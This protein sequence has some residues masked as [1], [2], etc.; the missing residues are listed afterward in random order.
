[1]FIRE[2]SR[3]WM[4]LSSLRDWSH[5]SWIIPPVIFLNVFQANLL[6]IKWVG[7]ISSCSG[8]NSLTACQCYFIGKWCWQYCVSD[9]TDWS[10]FA[11]CP[12]TAGQSSETGQNRA[13]FCIIPLLPWK[14]T[15]GF[16]QDQRMSPN[17]RGKSMTSCATIQTLDLA[18]IE[19]QCDTSFLSG[20]THSFSLAH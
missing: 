1:M 13:L 5:S 11:F 12:E 4:C 3:F 10:R 8:I 2:A 9:S 16:T 20:T 18:F 19:L 7:Q 6:L 15:A 14:Q 17:I